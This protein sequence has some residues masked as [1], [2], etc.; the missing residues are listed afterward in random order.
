MARIPLA[1]IAAALCLLGTCALAAPAGTM[2]FSQTGSQIVDANGVPRPAQ[3]GDVLQ[4]GET[5]RTPLGGISQVLMPDGSILGVRRKPSCALTRL[6]AMPR[7]WCPC[8]RV[9]YA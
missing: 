8:C 3:R 9:R 1:P 2:L 7:P 5:L 6:R 4:H